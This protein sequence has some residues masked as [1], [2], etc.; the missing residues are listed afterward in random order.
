MADRS[1]PQHSGLDTKRSAT[2][3]DIVAALK[4]LVRAS[5]ALFFT[6]IASFYYWQWS[7]KAKIKRATR[8]ISFLVIILSSVIFL[9]EG[10]AELIGAKRCIEA[11]SAIP[12]QGSVRLALFLSAALFILLH[13]RSEMKKPEYES[14]FIEGLLNAMSRKR[15]GTEEMKSLE[16]FHALFTRVNVSHVSFYELDNAKSKM[17]IKDVYP[18][19]GLDASYYQDLM[20]G[21]GVAGRV[22]QDKVPRYVARLFLS[23]RFR[24]YRWCYMP[25]AL[26]FP[27]LET[28]GKFK[29][30]ALKLKEGDLEADAVFSDD[31]N[32]LE[33]SSFLCVPILDPSGGDIIGV[34]NFDFSTSGRLNL[35]DITMAS[36]L[37][38]WFGLELIEK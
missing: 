13:H 36:V 33:F 20:V 15:S 30:V 12:L 25:H 5:V 7:R 35:V 26:T 27:L 21:D 19:T 37:G 31:P 16:I 34:L 28:Q 10:T 18:K 14:D 23:K 9:L 32:K 1:E 38:R 6:L 22:Y 4:A 11:L 29:R 2:V 8:T 3:R 24:K 17:Q